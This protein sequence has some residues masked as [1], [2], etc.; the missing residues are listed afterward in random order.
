MVKKYCPNCD[1]LT[2]Q[3][4]R[5]VRRIYRGVV[6]LHRCLK[7]GKGV[8]LTL[9]WHDIP[10]DWSKPPMEQKMHYRIEIVDL[11]SRGARSKIER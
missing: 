6:F 1:G 2:E 7:C 5:A 4:E 10:Y 8:R 11:G 9:D 3:E